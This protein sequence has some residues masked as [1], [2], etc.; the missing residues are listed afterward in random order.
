[1]TRFSAG[2]TALSRNRTAWVVSALLIAAV[3]AH[4]QTEIRSLTGVI[5]GHRVGGV[6]VDL[7]GNI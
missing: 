2:R 4:A 5:E 6:T 3:S 1:M 7:I